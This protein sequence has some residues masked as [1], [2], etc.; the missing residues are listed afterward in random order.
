MIRLFIFSLYIYIFIIKSSQWGWDKYFFSFFFKKV[1][2][3][4]IHKV[5]RHFWLFIC[6]LFVRQYCHR[7]NSEQTVQISS[8]WVSNLCAVGCFKMYHTQNWFSSSAKLQV[9][10][11]LSFLFK[12]LCS[13][14]QIL[15][16]QAL[17]KFALHNC[18]TCFALNEIF[19]KFLSFYISFP[20]IER[21]EERYFIIP[22]FLFLSLVSPE[23]KD[24]GSK[25]SR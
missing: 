12:Y 9:Q 21:I 2:S 10:V 11:T 13:E 22:L 24:R 6:K 3:I 18:V 20:S 1:I 14:F 4:W 15:F 16:Q 17:G 7:P 19:L 23:R 8:K 5:L 25:T